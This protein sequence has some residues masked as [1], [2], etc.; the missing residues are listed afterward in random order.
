MVNDVIF[1]N[2]LESGFKL[3]LFLYEN[4]KCGV[5]NCF[6]LIWQYLFCKFVVKVLKEIKDNL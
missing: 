4:K 5:V 1:L 2:D 3:F 6:L